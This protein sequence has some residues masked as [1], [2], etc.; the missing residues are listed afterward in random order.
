MN[1]TITK[2]E[3]VLFQYTVENMGV[4]YNG[5]NM[6]YEQGSRHKLDGGLLR[7]PPTGHCRRIRGWSFTLGRRGSISF[8]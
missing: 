7:I 4:D 2:L 8:R 1:P 3:T 6:V 5:F